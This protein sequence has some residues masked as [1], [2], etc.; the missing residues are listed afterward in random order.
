MKSLK[1]LSGGFVSECRVLI[2]CEAALML[3]FAGIIFYSLLYPS[4]Y[5]HEVPQK[6]PFYAVDLTVLKK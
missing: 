2:H 4:A 5:L 3:F 6:L 1:G